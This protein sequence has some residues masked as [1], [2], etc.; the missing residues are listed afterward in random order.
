MRKFRFW[1]YS[2]VY[3][4]VGKIFHQSL[5]MLV[6]KIERGNER[7]SRLGIKYKSR[8]QRSA[9]AQVRQGPAENEAHQ[10]CLP[11]LRLGLR[12]G[13]SRTNQGRNSTIYLR[14]LV[15]DS[16]GKTVISLTKREKGGLRTE[17]C[18]FL[19]MDMIW[20]LKVHCSNY[21][22]HFKCWVVPQTSLVHGW[23]RFGRSISPRASNQ[24]QEDEGHLHPQRSGAKCLGRS[25]WGE[26]HIITHLWKSKR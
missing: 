19:I 11:H 9:R 13:R 18:P 23:Q 8:S 4:T 20:H 17:E 3:N 21:R 2:L 1:T 10:G 16:V 22:S 12:C 25:G 6:S 14:I 26:M 5:T 24:S 7:A 15:I